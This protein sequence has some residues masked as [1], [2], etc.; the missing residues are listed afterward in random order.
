LHYSLKKLEPKLPLSFKNRILLYTFVVLIA[1]VIVIGAILQIVVFPQ[2]EADPTIILNL[3]IIHLVASLVTIVVGWVSISIIS[4]R[5]T[6]PL[7]ELTL[8]ADQISREVG[9]D[10]PS[11]PFGEIRSRPAA[12]TQHTDEPARADE[13]VQLRTSFY[14]MLAHL[15]ASEERLRNSEEKY[16]FL[17]DNG[18]NPL[19]VLDT[20]DMTIVDLNNRAMDVY[21][22]D[23]DEL[24]GKQ[25][26]DLAAPE[27]RER[28]EV[29]LKK[30]ITSDPFLVPTLQ[31]KRK[32]ASTLMVHLQPHVHWF[33]DRPAIIVA[34]WDVTEKLEQESRILQ[35]SKMATLGEMATGIAHELNQPLNVI[36]IGAD[37]LLKNIRRRTKLTEEQIGYIASELGENVDRAARIINHLRQ[38]GHSVDQSM[39]PMNLNDPVRGAFTLLGAQLEKK[40]IELKLSLDENLPP[41][42]GDQNRLEQVLINLV[43]N[44]KDVLV[45]YEKDLK[46]QGKTAEKVLHIKTFSEGDRVIVTIRDS[47]PGVPQSIRSKIFEPFFTTKKVGEG[48][49]L[50]L[51]IS[52]GIIKE[53]NGTIEVDGETE[54][55]AT[56]KL[57]F[58][59]LHE[60]MET[61]HGEDPSH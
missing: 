37:Y 13:I 53:H 19:F 23:K 36:K 18:P 48:T 34:I 21:Q 24:V 27:D 49:G 50:G 33:Q 51:S 47:G 54:P 44:S 59:A 32:D 7:Q 3:K 1:G 2:M 11:D 22:F 16:R 6:L 40:G 55:G 8:R 57:T 17:F 31:H 42:L 15:K 9:E 60:V 30:L 26:S 45:Q 14:R 20:L 61:D 46:E 56:F 5:I 28:T 43:I 58:P 25:L 12:T 38:F 41:I 29:T 39:Y 10:S 52:Y 4:R 35:A